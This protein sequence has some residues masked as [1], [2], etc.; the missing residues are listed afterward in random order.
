MKER[1]VAG[2]RNVDGTIPHRADGDGRTVIINVVDGTTIDDHTSW[3]TLLAGVSGR[4]KSLSEWLSN[5]SRLM[6]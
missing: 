3:S 4:G 5:D 2:T 6:M 1:I